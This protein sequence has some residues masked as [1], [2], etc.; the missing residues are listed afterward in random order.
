M[1]KMFEFWD[2]KDNNLDINMGEIGIQK[3]MSEDDSDD[4]I[5]QNLPVIHTIFCKKLTC[6]QSFRHLCAATG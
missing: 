6:I 1:E 4:S 3:V 2:I 5:T